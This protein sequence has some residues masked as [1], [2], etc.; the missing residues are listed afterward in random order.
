MTTQRAAGKSTCEHADVACLN[1]YELIRKYRCSSCNGVMICA[2]DEPFGRRFWDHRLDEG[3]ELETQRRVPVTL[4]FQAAVCNEC[5][6][7]PAEAAPHAEGWGCTTK[8][9]RYCW[10]EHF[11][12]TER[13]FAD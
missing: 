6:G 5:R 9:R 10:R 12:E 3:C 11:F 8:V 13:R 2:C 4:G 7:L 1:Q